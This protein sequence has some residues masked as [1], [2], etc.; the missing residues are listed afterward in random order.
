MRSTL[1]RKTYFF[2]ELL[3]WYGMVA[4]LSAYALLS[5]NYLQPHQLGYQLLN[6]TGA[7]GLV[8]DAYYKKDQPVVVLN[9]I[10]VIIAGISLLRIWYGSA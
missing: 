6:G 10:F 3:G 4:I 1:H 9:L 2:S 7:L 5:F 8:V